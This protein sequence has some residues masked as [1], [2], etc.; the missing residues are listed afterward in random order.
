MGRNSF[1]LLPSSS[2]LHLI[3]KMLFNAVPFVAA[4]FTTQILAVP[5]TEAIEKRACTVATAVVRKDW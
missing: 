5:V 1:S 3:F 4:F 2:I